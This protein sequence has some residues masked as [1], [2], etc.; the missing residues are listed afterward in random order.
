MIYHGQTDS[1][2]VCLSQ[3]Y[4]MNI[5]IKQMA[6]TYGPALIENPATWKW[7]VRIP[8]SYYNLWIF[9]SGEAEMTLKKRVFT[10][11]RPLYFLLRPGE[12]VSAVNRSGRSMQNFFL[13]IDCKCVKEPIPDA[14]ITSSWGTPI[15]NYDRFRGWAETAE[16]LWHRGD[17]LSR[18]MSTQIAQLMFHTFWQDITTRPADDRAEKILALMDAVRFHPEEP[19]RIEN[20]AREHHLSRSQFTRRFTDTAG[21]SPRAFITR[22]R[23]NKAIRL[24]TE[25]SLNIS[26]VAEALNYNDV[27]YFSRQFKQETGH[28]PSFYRR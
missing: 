28:P 7:Q 8:E 27:F 14:L 3:R 24:L 17:S 15:R 4:F 26:E 12:C 19:W 21:C 16:Q 25:S 1:I 5:P 22:C 20:M 23:I 11:D 2:F 6:L 9:F 18:A 13:H 10:L